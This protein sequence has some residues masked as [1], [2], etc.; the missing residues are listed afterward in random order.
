MQ[1]IEGT[2]PKEICKQHC[3]NKCTVS[4]IKNNKET[5]ESFSKKIIQSPKNIKIIS[6]VKVPIIE[7]ALY[8]WFLNERLSYKPVND[9]MLRLKAME[10]HRNLNTDISFTESHGWIQKFKKRHSIRLL[11]ICREKLSSGFISSL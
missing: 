9:E 2:R 7:H 11:K 6:K 1:Y 5:I 4:R 10:F 3:L 8:Q